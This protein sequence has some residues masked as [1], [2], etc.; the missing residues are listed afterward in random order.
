MGR[1][2]L[3]KR[4]SKIGWFFLWGVMHRQRMEIQEGKLEKERERER[5]RIKKAGDIWDMK[6]IQA[7]AI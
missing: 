3:P 1:K 2:M 5:E 6:E 7:E 4:R